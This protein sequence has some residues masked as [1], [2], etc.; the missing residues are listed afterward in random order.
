MNELL[1]DINAIIWFS[2]AFILI[3]GHL[4]CADYY[5]KIEEDTRTIFWVALG[6]ATFFGGMMFVVASSQDGLAQGIKWGI[7]TFTCF[8]LLYY[9]C[10]VI[11]GICV[12]YG[13]THQYF[14]RKRG[15]T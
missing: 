12:M 11:I 2:T 10:I 4:T 5:H 3:I 14:K 15:R 7:G 1:M 8:T 9:A 6:I 13:E